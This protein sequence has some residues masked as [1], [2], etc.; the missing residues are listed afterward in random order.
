LRRIL[1]FKSWATYS[2]ERSRFMA[3]KLRK[4]LSCFVGWLK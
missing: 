2:N 4:C 1:A 3:I